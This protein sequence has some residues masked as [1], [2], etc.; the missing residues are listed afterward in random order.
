MISFAV[1]VGDELR[2]SSSE[3]LLAER[4]QPVETFFVDRP[5][6]AFRVGIRIR[7]LIRR[8]HDAHA[9]LAEP[10]ADRRGPLPIAIAD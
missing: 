1:I 2:D 4:N 3:V 8:S 9:N 10:L 5:H 7:G 6:E